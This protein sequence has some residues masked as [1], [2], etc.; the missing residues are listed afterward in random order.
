LGLDFPIA[1]YQEV[2]RTIVGSFEDIYAKLRTWSTFFATEQKISKMKPSLLDFIR[3]TVSQDQ[4][5]MKRLIYDRRNRRYLVEA[6][7]SSVIF[8][9]IFEGFDHESKAPSSP[10]DLWMPREMA[11]SV[12]LI[13]TTLNDNGE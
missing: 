10:V 7:A 12:H 13:E 6:R 8:S 2:D 1:G 5:D 11:S 3:A 4:S 9:R